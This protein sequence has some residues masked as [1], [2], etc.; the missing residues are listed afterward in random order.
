MTENYREAPN[1]VVSAA[2][3]ITYAYREVGVGPLPLV[4]LQHFRGN[5]DNWDPA[6]VDELAV[7]RRVI[8]FDNAGV[9]GSSGATPNT[10]VQMANDA[11]SAHIGL[12]RRTLALLGTS[13]T[14]FV[15]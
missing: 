3:G 12:L 13:Q 14:S 9:G 10:I 15:A 8:A 5:L 2:N 4:L 6:L 11:I 7:D 1:K